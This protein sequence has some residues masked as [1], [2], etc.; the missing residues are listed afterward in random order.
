MT[1]TAAPLS[2]SVP[3]TQP[4]T[5]IAS[6]SSAA[7]AGGSVINVSSLVSQLV[8]A[9]EAPQQALIANQTQQVTTQIS[10]LGQLKGALSTFQSSLGALDSPSAF[11]LETAN[12][13]APTVFTA[14]AGNGA[15]A[16]AYNVSVSAL[17]TAQQ[18][19]SKPVAGPTIGTGTLQLSLGSTSFSVAVDS[20]DNTLAGLAAAINSASGN[21]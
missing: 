18:L 10:A 12:S 8:A 15:P 3:Q 11:Q 13:S 17:A 20:S 2:S 9:T 21:P 7:A 4:V 19:L 6:T 16:G 5:T 1:T 14:T